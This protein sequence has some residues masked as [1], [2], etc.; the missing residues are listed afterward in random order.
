MRAFI[1]VALLLTSI[2]VVAE[3][4]AATTSPAP[5]PPGEAAKRIT[6][7]PGF[8]AT[9][10]AGEPDVVQ[11]IATAIDDRGRLWVAECLS[12]PKWQS[13]PKAGHDR[14]VIFEDANGDGHFSKKTVFAD[15]I[16]NLSSLEIGFGGVWVCSAPNLLFIPLD[17]SRDRPAGEPGGMLDGWEIK[18]AR[19]KSGNRFEW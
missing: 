2:R 17:P 10:F 5:L 19:H 3:T 4:P 1:F 9:I 12:Y 14:I 13:D 6:V 18:S 8:S 16:S 7:P 11:P 15:N